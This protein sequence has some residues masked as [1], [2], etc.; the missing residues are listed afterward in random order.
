MREGD[1]CVDLDDTPT[2]RLPDKPTLPFCTK[3]IVPL[4]LLVIID[5]PA[6]SNKNLKQFLLVYGKDQALTDSI[7]QEARSEAKAQLFGKEDG[8]IH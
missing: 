5:T 8:N 1:D 7:F 3:W 4:I 2:K 6:I